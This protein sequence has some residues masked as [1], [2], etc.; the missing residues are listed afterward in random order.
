M[1]ELGRRAADTLKTLGHSNVTVKIGDG[2]SGWPEFAPFDR[3]IVTAAPDHVPQP[4]VDQ[5][6]VGG[7]MVVPVGPAGG[8]QQLVVLDK[9]ATALVRKDRAGHLRSADTKALT[10]VHEDQKATKI[11]KNTKKNTKKNTGDPFSKRLQVFSLRDLAV[12][13]GGPWVDRG[14]LT[15]TG[16]GRR[17]VGVPKLRAT[18]GVRG[19]Q[20]T[21]A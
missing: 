6:A 17:L 10:T 13:R 4:L 7:R 15:H 3:I 16:E 9:T 1:P 14:C 12:H 20:V 21:G 18:R 11:T 19:T 2:Y 5:L 8:F